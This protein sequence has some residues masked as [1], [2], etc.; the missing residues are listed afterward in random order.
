MEF[1]PQ[2]GKIF[3]LFREYLYFGSDPAVVLEEENEKLRLLK[4]Y[5]DSI[6]V[7]DLSMNKPNIDS[8][9][10]NCLISNYAR[11]ITINNVY[12]YM[13]SLGIKLEKRPD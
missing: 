1:T 8:L 6:L 4:S 10:T 12:E 2:R 5:I 3:S 13:R 7:R 11:L 9:F